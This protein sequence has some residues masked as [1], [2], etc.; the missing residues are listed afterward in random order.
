MTPHLLV[1]GVHGCRLPGG[2]ARSSRHRGNSVFL[3]V[4]AQH[5]TLTPP[6]AT[7]VR[8]CARAQVPAGEGVGE[9]SLQSWE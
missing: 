1:V 9:F 6:L 2:G 8:P 4:V 7:Q 3:D 5:R